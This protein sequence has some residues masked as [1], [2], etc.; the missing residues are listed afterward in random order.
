M[1]RIIH[2]VLVQDVTPPTDGTYPYDLPINPLSHIWLTLKALNNG[3]NTKATLP[4]LLSALEKIEVLFRGQ[5]I[6]SMNGLDLYAL[7]T[8]MLGREPWQENVINTDNATRALTICIPLTRIPFS[9]H[10]CF[11]ATSK[12]ELQLQLQ[13]DIADIGYDGVIFQIETVELPDAK[14]TTFMKATSLTATPTVA[15][16]MDVD[17]PI[18]NR[19]AGILMWGTTIPSGTSWTATIDQARLLVDNIE[20]MYAKTNWETLHGTG[21][22]RAGPP[23]AWGEKFHME[24]LAGVYTQNADSA[25]QEADDTDISNHAYMDFSPLRDDQYIV[26][27]KGKSRVN[28][29][30]VAGDTN[31][32]RVIPI[33]IVQVAGAR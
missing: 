19:L 11:F 25:T 31:P 26:D 20:H 8:F 10:E 21:M 6:L 15:G 13:I 29:R 16:E 18:G 14:P 9:P 4:Q 30:I 17:L 7:N 33:E 22:L 28:L 32:L 3:I 1:A 27:T 23:N 24:N 5:A 12:G 2:S